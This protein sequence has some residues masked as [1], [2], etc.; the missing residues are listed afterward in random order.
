MNIEEGQANSIYRNGFN[1]MIGYV[2]S[3]RKAAT[4]KDLEWVNGLLANLDVNKTA[5][6][7]DWVK[8]DTLKYEQSEVVPN[9]LEYF[10][11]NQIAPTGMPLAIASGKGDATNR[12]TLNTHLQLLQ[13]NLRELVKKTISTFERFIFERIAKQNE[14][15]GIAHIEWGALG[16]SE[17]ELTVKYV[18]TAVKE[19]VISA[20]EARNVISNLLN[21][22]L[23]EGSA[24][25][26]SKKNAKKTEENI[27]NS[28]TF[29]LV[30]G[31]KENIST[32]EKKIEKL[33]QDT[34]VKIKESENTISLIKE[35]VDKI[36]NE[37]E[38]QDV[39]IDL[40]TKEKNI[41][42]MKRKANL[43]KKLEQDVEND[44]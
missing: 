12:S 13:S 40:L 39:K 7:P 32:M 1:P 20:E 33:N 17:I 8:V 23:K 43:I 4:P 27:K 2:G 31:L 30:E 29:H 44:K 18:L 26:V 6:L 42:L 16:L 15:D 38:S 14:V 11:I 36:K 9:T 21:L 28:E 22:N 34:E 35:D 24:P 37:N 10:R 5:A 3:E 19:G 41:N 25:P